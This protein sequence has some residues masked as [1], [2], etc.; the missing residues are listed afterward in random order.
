MKKI[1]FI[2]LSV[3]TLNFAMAQMNLAIGPRAGFGHSWFSNTPGGVKNLYHPAGNFGASIVYSSQSNFG[4]SADI[5]YSI[6]GNK[7]EGNGIGG[8][9][10]KYENRLG[11]LRIPVQGIYFFGQYG[12]K[13]RP[14][15]SAGP[16]FGFLMSGKSYT[17]GKETGDIKDNFKGFDIGLHLSPGV[18]V[19]LVE[20]T[21]L[22]ADVGYYHGFSDITELPSAPDSKNRNIQVNL[23]VIFG[24]GKY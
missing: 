18:H 8:G 19:N 11:Y 16:S 23:G 15:I 10:A 4:I 13:M 17:D 21:W 1:L 7:F 6:E 14:K 3:F 2:T 20:N 22:V 5:L 9:I 24:I 12:D